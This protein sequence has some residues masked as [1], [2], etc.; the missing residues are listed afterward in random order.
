MYSGAEGDWY[1]S[2]HPIS[3]NSTTNR[4]KLSRVRV[5]QD[6]HSIHNHQ[7]KTQLHDTLGPGLHCSRR[8][9]YLL[10][11]HPFVPQTCIPEHNFTNLHHIESTTPPNNSLFF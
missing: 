2:S 4:A 11:T 10:Q 5:Q 7:T 6:R 8:I 3:Q 9:V 1:S